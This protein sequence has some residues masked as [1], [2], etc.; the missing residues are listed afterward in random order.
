M[1]HILYMYPPLLIPSPA[2]EQLAWFYN[3]NVLHSVLQEMLACRFLCAM[4]TWIP[5][6][7]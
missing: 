1:Y 5:G 4:L 6:V 2:D 7:L 3:V